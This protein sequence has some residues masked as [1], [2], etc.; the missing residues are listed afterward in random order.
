M[1]LTYEPSSELLHISRNCCTFRGAI[2]AG[3]L[4][5]VVKRQSP[6]EAVI[7][8][9]QQPC[10]DTVSPYLDPLLHSGVDCTTV[11]F[12]TVP[13]P[14]PFT[15][16]PKPLPLSSNP[17]PAEVRAGGRWHQQVHHTDRDARA[18]LSCARARTS[19]ARAVSPH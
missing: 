10:P 13:C 17:F 3:V 9:S 4:D 8:K 7:F 18:M 2:H 11:A 14:S 1:R 19:R 12:L 16:V 6:L 15:L 5:G